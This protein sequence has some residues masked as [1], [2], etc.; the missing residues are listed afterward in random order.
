MRTLSAK[1]TSTPPKQ[2]DADPE[3]SW[4]SIDMYDPDPNNDTSGLTDAP[5]LPEGARAQSWQTTEVIDGH[6]VTTVARSHRVN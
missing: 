1:P 5:P 2:N 6:T 3:G 4:L